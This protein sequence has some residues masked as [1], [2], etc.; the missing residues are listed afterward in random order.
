MSSVQIVQG[1]SATNRIVLYISMLLSPAQFVA[2][3]GSNCPSNI[4]FLVYNWYTQLQWYSA[5]RHKQLHAWSLLVSEFNFCFTITYLGGVSSGNALSAYLLG[6]GTVGVMILN[7]VVAWTSWSTSQTEGYGVYQFWFWGWKTFGKGWHGWFCWIQIVDT[8]MLIFTAAAAFN[9]AFGTAMTTQDK[10][11]PWWYRYQ[12]VIGGSVGTLMA[13][14][15]LIMWTELTIRRNSIASDTDMTAVWLF[16]VQ[17]MTMLA[18]PCFRCCMRREKNSVNE[19]DEVTPLNVLMGSFRDDI[20]WEPQRPG[21][22]SAPTVYQLGQ[23][24]P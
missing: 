15:P 17:A 7:N 4:G 18:P 13:I 21:S 5:A 2:G 8:I 22:P 12:V 23:I 16:V 20:P 19:V 11:P 24:A 1:F 14:W 10:V 9:L 3:L 6:Y